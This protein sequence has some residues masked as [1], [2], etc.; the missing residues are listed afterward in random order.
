[1][2]VEA[3]VKVATSPSG[4]SLKCVGENAVHFTLMATIK[5]KWVTQGIR[6]RQYPLPYGNTLC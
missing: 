5:S 4:V 6:K 2:G 3:A 1:M